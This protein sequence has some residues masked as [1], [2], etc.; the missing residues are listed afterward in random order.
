MKT[1]AL[2]IALLLGGTALAQNSTTSGSMGN[3]GSGDMTAGQNQA[4]SGPGTAGYSSQSSTTDMNGQ[5]GQPQVGTDSSTDQATTTGSTANGQMQTGSTGDQTQTG[6]NGTSG[7]TNMAMNTAGSTGSVVQPDNS[8]PRRD[9][10]GVRVISLAAVVPA[11]WNGTASG[12]TGMGGPLLDPTTGQAVSGTGSYPPCSRG[13][14]D[15]CVQTYERHR[16]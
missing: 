12:N 10:R 11:G 8:N 5:N 6:W 15:K 16:R 2:G 3:N 9:R 4:A 7:Q 14:T 13:M 1:L